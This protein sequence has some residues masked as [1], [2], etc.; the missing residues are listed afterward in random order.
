MGGA[1]AALPSGGWR[2]AGVVGIGELGA[3]ELGGC[4]ELGWRGRG[5]ESGSRF[6]LRNFSGVFYEGDAGKFDFH[7]GGQYRHL[8]S[9]MES[10]GND[11]EEDILDS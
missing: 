9:M 1:G 8:A 2:S 3:G 10:V 11:V 6:P 7:I 4:V 5:V